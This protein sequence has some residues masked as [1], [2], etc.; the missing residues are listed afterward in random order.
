MSKFKLLYILVL[1]ASMSSCDPL[2]EVNVTI[3][4]NNITTTDMMIGVLDKTDVKL[5]NDYNIYNVLS[6]SSNTKLESYVS[7][8]GTGMAGAKS[9]DI[10]VYNKVDSTYIILNNYSDKRELYLK[11]VREEYTNM[12]TRT[13]HNSANKCDLNITII[14]DDELLLKMTKNTALTDSIFNLKK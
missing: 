9:M 13:K 4:A 3:L 6:G 8:D 14:I 1:I 5:S 10:I 7:V 12:P 11:H 2:W